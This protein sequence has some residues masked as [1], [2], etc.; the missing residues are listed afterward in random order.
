[1]D[2][3]FEIIR[4]EHDFVEKELKDFENALGENLP[5]SATLLHFLKE[6]RDFWELHEY[7]EEIIFDVLR[8]NN[9][10][11]RTYELSFEHGEIK[12]RKDKLIR[13]LE[14]E[15]SNTNVIKNEANKLIM[16]IREHKEKEDWILLNV[17]WEHI[18]MYF[19]EELQ[20]VKTFRKL[21][22][23]LNSKFKI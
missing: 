1:M 19:G 17:P 7:K 6:L 20:E 10:K 13:E 9:F 21:T 11:L 14:F 12:K 18:K 22:S 8:R 3:L 15:N 16:Q 5:D 2:N 4:K 23:E